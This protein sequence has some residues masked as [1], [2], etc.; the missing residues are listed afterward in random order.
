[1]VRESLRRAPPGTLPDDTNAVGGYWTRNNDPEIDIVGAD[2]EPI[3]KRVT[4]VGSIKWLA[5]QPFDRRDLHRL[6]VHRAK[7]PGADE[8]TPLIA[9]ARAGIE[10]EGV[11]AVGPQELLDAWR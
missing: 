9:V 10:A 8:D 11:T 6:V 5:E 1:M 2:R 7:L 3:A 4:A